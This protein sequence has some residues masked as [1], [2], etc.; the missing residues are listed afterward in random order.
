MKGQVPVRI[1]IGFRIRT[2]M[3]WSCFPLNTFFLQW[4]LGMK[5]SL[6]L[7]AQDFVS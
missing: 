4:S 3:V 1:R 7:G 6:S 5:S 2:R